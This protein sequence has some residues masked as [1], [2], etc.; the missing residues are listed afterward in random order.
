M[1]I[2]KK[3]TISFIAISLLTLAVGLVSLLGIGILNKELERIALNRLPSVQALLTLAEAQSATDAAQKTL[4][5]PNL[6]DEERLA[7]LTVIEDAAIRYDGAWSN[8]SLLE[9]EPEETE[10]IN[11]LS[12]LWAMWTEGSRIFMELESAYETEG[13]QEAYEAMRN[14]VMTDNRTVYDSSHQLLGEL[15]QINL[16][17]AEMDQM[18]AQDESSLVTQTVIAAVIISFGISLGLGLFLGGRMIKPIRHLASELGRLAESGGDLTSPIA[19]S[20][21]D[22]IGAMAGAVN[23]FIEKIRAIVAETIDESQQMGT[24]ASDSK[25]QMMAMHQALMEISATTQQL[26]AGMQQTAV[27]SEGISATLEDLEAVVDALGSQS[28]SCHDFAVNSAEKA[29]EICDKAQKAKSAA[30]GLFESTRQTMEQ[31]IDNTNAVSQIQLLSEGIMDIS[32]QTNLLALNA[33]IEAARAGDAGRGFGVVASEI[34]KLAD[35]S[36]QR[37]GQIQAVTGQIEQAVGQLVKSAHQMIHFMEHQVIADYS[38]LEQ[39]G[40][41]YQ[42]DA[43][44]YKQMSE[45]LRQMSETMDS[46]FDGV[47]ASVEEI[48]RAAGESSEGAHL[49]AQKNIRITEYGSEA[50]EQSSQIEAIASR[51]IT[52]L[53][54]FQVH[55]QSQNFR[56]ISELP[57][58]L[59]IAESAEMTENSNLLKI[60]QE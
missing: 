8:Y 15:S 54:Q 56:L 26:S 48:A 60:T 36:Q 52:K 33:A 35:A 20:A 28:E 4:L 1:S 40:E 23:D 5:Q 2:S 51:L 11:Q 18:T 59:E 45:Q 21:K 27:S 50:L 41:S 43:V 47:R 55:P 44:Y 10:L 13:T 53:S 24:D 22:E 14:Q 19:V 49:I 31:A 32:S 17:A 3:M 29:S 38:A 7:L 37:V 46:A 16:S 25:R 30:L 6:T 57:E 39:T 42:S 58:S 34:K 9:H 12:E